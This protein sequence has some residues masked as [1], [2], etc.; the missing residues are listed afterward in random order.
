MTIAILSWLIAT[1]LPQVAQRVVDSGHFACQKTAIV[2]AG[3]HF[4]GVPEL[5]S[6]S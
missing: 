4:I 3:R 6:L 2:L 1:L 5:Q